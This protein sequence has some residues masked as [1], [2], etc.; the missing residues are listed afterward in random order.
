MNKAFR[1]ALRDIFGDGALIIFMVI[2]PIV[3]P[4][5]Y[6]L[7]YNTEAVHEVPVVVVDKAGN[8][9]SRD[10]LNR[11][12][13]SPD[14]HIA[15]H[16]TSLEAAKAAVARREA[17][18]VVYIPEDFAQKLAR[19]EQT[20][21]SV[22]CDMSGMLY[23]K[24]ILA[25]ATDVSLKM[26]ARIKIQRAG[27]TTDRQDELTAHPLEY[28]HIALFNPQSGFASFLLPAVL[29]LIIQQTMIL[30]V[31][32]EA[33]TRRERME[34]THRLTRAERLKQW[35]HP[36]RTRLRHAS[37]R[38]LRNLLGRAAAFFVIYIPV[39][40]YELGVVPH[41]FHFPQV[42]HALDIALFALPFLLACVFF[43]IS[44]SGIPKSRESIILIAVF[45]SVPMLFLS[46]VSWPG[47]AI[48][49]YWKTLA[50]LTPSTFGVNGFVRLNTMGASLADVQT[51]Y[52]A[53]W[54][55]VVV[56]GIL[57]WWVT[58]KNEVRKIQLRHYMPSPTI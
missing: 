40:A 29:I 53:L 44:I 48:P 8:A 36:R 1:H 25:S 10:F 46:G 5:V 56:Y 32:M 41:L 4:I 47:S 27:N 54:I 43:A 15:A 11:L 57:A 55:H 14:V 12:D 19:M 31:G 16:A 39:T 6:A 3:Y 28:E 18:G 20:R 38:A 34:Q 17:Y 45:T 23:Y 30:G 52:F 37:R 2:V 24:A 13:A 35:F 58:R 49:W 50:N 9:T 33:G 22:Y 42:G 51:E 7:I 21:V 26:N